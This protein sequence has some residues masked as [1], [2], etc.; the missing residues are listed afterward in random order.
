MVVKVPT[1]NLTV[2]NNPTPTPYKSANAP[3]A[4]F[5]NAMGTDDL[6]RG[7][8]LSSKAIDEIQDQ[9]DK[10]QA[11]ESYN[12]YFTNVMNQLHDKDNGLFVKKGK[13]AVD[14]VQSTMNNLQQA[15]DDTLGTCNNNRQKMYLSQMINQNMQDL[16][17]RIQDFVAEQNQVWKKQTLEDTINTQTQ[18]AIINKY[19]TKSIYTSI[20]NARASV[21]ALSGETDPTILK[22]MQDDVTSNMLISVIE[23]RVGDKALNAKEFFDAHKNDIDPAKW[24]GIEKIINENDA[25]VRSRLMADEWFKSGISEEDAFNKAHSIKDLDLRDSTEKQVSYLYGRKREMEHQAKQD[26]EDKVWAQLEQNPDINLIPSSLDHSTKEAMKDYCLTGGKGKSDPDTY[27]NLYEMSATNAEAFSKVDLNQYRDKL[28]KD[29]YK[30]FVK[31]Q[32]DIRMHGYSDITTDN[33]KVIEVADALGLKKK[34]QA[35]IA[36]E[37]KSLIQAEERRLGRK[38][39]ASEQ[40]QFIEY[41]GYTGGKEASHKIIDEHGGR[42]DFYK[43]VTNDV[44][45]FQKVHGRLPDGKEFNNIL[46]SRAANTMQTRNNNTYKQMI[47]NTQAKPHETKE[48]TYYA[49]KYLPQLGKQLGIKITVVPGGRFNPRAKGYDSYHNVNGVAQAVDVS[50]S[51]HTLSE[52][53]KL[54]KAQLNNPMVRK[55]GTSD[56]NLLALYGGNSKVEDESRFDAIHGTNHKNHM[57]IT[58]NVNNNANAAVIAHNQSGSVRMKAPNGHIYNVPIGQ[59]AEYQKIGGVKI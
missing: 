18:N 27:I 52:R 9:N 50:M 58:L 6:G 28:T 13:D 25:D 7:V 4:A 26:V 54:F 16:Q 39:N 1:F 38:L 5:N 37:A 19:D 59:V 23:G 34:G 40:N 44:T 51:E 2:S 15:K 53:E 10:T 46:Y 48:V 11:A 43:S 29:E 24:A 57:H 55:I 14:S 41:F 22:K 20:G 30:T 21:A 8:I 56:K 31:R 42:A 17:P 47:Q 45:A 12:G 32:S 33:D 49:D 36:T 35:A 3:E